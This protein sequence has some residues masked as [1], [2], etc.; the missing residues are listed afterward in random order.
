MLLGA[1]LA[2]GPAG[3]HARTG[4]RLLLAVDGANPV[5]QALAQNLAAR[6]TRV[7]FPPHI[8]AGAPPFAERIASVAPALEAAK[9]LYYNAQFAE[10]AAKTRALLMVHT[11]DL[12]LAGELA[13]LR[14]LRL[15]TGIAL[16]RVGDRT[17]ALEAFAEAITL[18][19][20]PLDATAFPPEVLGAFSVAAR[21]LAK[22]P[23]GL[24]RLAV[25]PRNAKVAVDGRPL[26]SPEARLPAGHH[27]VVVRALGYLP[28]VQRVAVPATVDL[29]LERASTAQLRMQ[30]AELRRRGRL[31]LSDPTIVAALGRLRSVSHALVAEQQPGAGATSTLVL[32][33]VD[34]ANAEVKL[35]ISE[36]LTADGLDQ[37]AERAIGRLYLALFGRPRPIRPAKESVLK[38]WW[39]WTAVGVVVT[40]A[41]ATAVGLTLRR[42]AR[43]EISGTIPPGT[44]N[45]D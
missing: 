7:I 1:A 37:A 5:R 35:R 13:L 11:V 34:C 26:S 43:P 23:K 18:A 4:R 17:G 41:T 24:L 22:A 32:R 33:Y 10:A 44:V 31:S 9:K 3:A 40:A 21:Q 42:D 20:N 15:W 38:K 29:K 12:A 14:E 45:V 30:L 19:Q 25:E 6:G 8:A 16:A 27:W 39:F 28:Q 2:G 36:R